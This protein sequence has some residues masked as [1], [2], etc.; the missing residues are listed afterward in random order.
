[1]PLS[2]PE[3]NTE[4]RHGFIEYDI[5]RFALGYLQTGKRGLRDLHGEPLFWEDPGKIEA[6]FPCLPKVSCGLKIH[7]V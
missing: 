1:M 3:A 4:P 6:V 5:V 7:V 2:P